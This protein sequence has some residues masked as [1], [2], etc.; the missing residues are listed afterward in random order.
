M[1]HQHGKL[2]VAANAP[3]RIGPQNCG[4][5]GALRPRQ[6]CSTNHVDGFHVQRDIPAEL[7]VRARMVRR[8]RGQLTVVNSRSAFSPARP[9]LGWRMEGK[10][11]DSVNQHSQHWVTSR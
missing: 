4:N 11:L 5:G 7:S 10:P 6:R 2:P 9:P 1:K 3:L 8:T